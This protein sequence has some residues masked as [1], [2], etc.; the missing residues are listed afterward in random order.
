MSVNNSEQLNGKF[1]SF[2]CLEQKT[3][4]EAFAEQIIQA[5]V[6]IRRAGILEYA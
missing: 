3:V 1:Y 4:S 6:K 5:T 2:V